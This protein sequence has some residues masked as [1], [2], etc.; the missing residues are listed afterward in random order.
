[1]LIR[2][3]EMYLS[4]IW[5]PDSVAEILPVEVK[6]RKRLHLLSWLWIPGVLYAFYLIEKHYDDY[7]QK[8]VTRHTH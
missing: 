8:E 3:R 1:M 4:A 5:G 7:S 2:K 6:D